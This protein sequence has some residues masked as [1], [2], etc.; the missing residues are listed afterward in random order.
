VVLRDEGAFPGRQ[1][2]KNEKSQAANP[3]QECAWSR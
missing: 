2:Q 1:P 3:K